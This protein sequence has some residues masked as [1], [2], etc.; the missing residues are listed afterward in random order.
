M[1]R[2]TLHM[3][4]ASA[5][6]LTFRSTFRSH[7]TLS[8]FIP[9]VRPL[10]VRALYAAPYPVRRLKTRR[11]LPGP[12][13]GRSHLLPAAAEAGL[14]LS[15][16]HR[17]ESLFGAGLADGR[18]KS[19]AEP[20][21]VLVFRRLRLL[22]RRT[23]RHRARLAGV[24]V[25]KRQ[26]RGG[27]PRLRPPPDP[28]SAFFTLPGVGETSLTPVFS[29]PGRS[30]RCRR[31]RRRSSSRGREPFVLRL[32]YGGEQG[33]S[34]MVMRPFRPGAQ[35]QGKASLP[36]FPP[37]AVSGLD[38]PGPAALAFKAVVT[39]VWL[40]R[41]PEGIRGDLLGSLEPDRGLRAFA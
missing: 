29:S 26:F 23:G 11:L 33:A 35:G 16:L 4:R 32:F 15:L 41:V 7:L 12:P 36:V 21:S 38:R 13:P 14:G 5:L 28:P 37:A 20:A 24:K 40:G 1:N 22:P 3:L 9:T 31:K 27:I 34:V 39:G 8:R 17:A 25:R 19:G 18:V 10:G 30:R 2:A 6:S